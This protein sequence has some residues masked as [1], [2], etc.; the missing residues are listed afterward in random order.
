[1]KKPENLNVNSSKDASDFSKGRILLVEDEAI[2]LESFKRDLISLGFEVDTALN[3]G[4][5][6]K[7]FHENLFDIVLTDI[8]IPN[9]EDG[10]DF[11][12][13]IKSINKDIPIIA[14]TGKRLTR[15]LLNEAGLDY[16]FTKTDV[17][18][19]SFEKSLAITSCIARYRSGIEIRKNIKL[20]E[21]SEKKFRIF[22]ENSSNMIFITNK[23]GLFTYTNPVV[24]KILGYT[25]E[26]MGNIRIEDLISE[27]N[28]QDYQQKLNS[29][30]EKGRFSITLVL[31]TKA[32]QSVYGE[33]RI[34][35]N[36]NK[37]DSFMGTHIV[38][39]D[40][41]Y[42]RYME[43]RL[44]EKE[45]KFRIILD[46]LPD[47]VIHIDREMKV[48]WA[49]KAALEASHD[50]TGQF[51]YKAFNRYDG[52]CNE[53]P[54][55]KAMKT[56]SNHRKIMEEENNEGSNKVYDC[57]ALPFIEENEVTGAIVIIRDITEQQRKTNEI[58]D[59][60]ESIRQSREQERQ[61]IAKDLHDG[62]GQTILAAKLNFQ[63]F[64]KD[65]EKYKERFDVGLEFIDKAS[66][67]LR[68][69]Y[70]NIF[71]SVLADLGLEAAVR[72]FCKQYLE[73]KGV[74]TE[75]VLDINN[76]LSAETE[77]NIYRILQEISS[78]IIKHSHA[79][80]VKI[81]I[82]NN[83]ERNLLDLEVTDNGLGFEYDKDK[84]PSG[85]FGLSDIQERVKSMQGSFDIKTSPGEGTMINIKVPLNV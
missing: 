78:N 6:I 29:V 53:C 68:E 39:H 20:M 66:Q 83:D 58:R 51:C 81:L 69:V 56:D 54:G 41:S 16:F 25:V 67:E 55:R 27:D 21:E 50:M 72:W 11:I 37:K 40:M 59:L 64:E 52:F 9:E 17:N 32:G 65:M 7:I 19:S 12:R 43:S 33:L 35:A 31:L 80:Y 61:R 57:L 2:I 48:I 22:M 38:F 34:A 73:A 77:V 47:M 1:M 74:T 85:S 63:T 49:N 10:Y 14:I 84:R 28:K 13:S 24:E 18:F 46:S 76:Q 15:E 5:A 36:Y 75:I 45:E 26:E 60:N 3:K 8:S 79:D 4:A 70:S 82:N 71:P 42:R 23:E 30:N 62:I 44:R